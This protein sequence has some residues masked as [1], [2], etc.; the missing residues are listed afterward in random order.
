[1]CSMS[2][3]NVSY[4]FVWQ[5]TRVYSYW[6]SETRLLIYFQVHIDCM[7]ETCKFVKTFER[8]LLCICD[9]IFDV[10]LHEVPRYY[11]KEVKFVILLNIYM[12]HLDTMTVF[13]FPKHVILKRYDCTPFMEFNK[14]RFYTQTKSHNHRNLR[15]LTNHSKA[16]LWEIKI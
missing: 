13:S 3:S 2:C 14:V 1:M 8:L 15:A 9:K 10:C 6:L 5:P 16:V 12:W 4:I 11:D 7:W